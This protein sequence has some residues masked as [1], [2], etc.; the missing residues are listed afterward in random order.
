VELF[1][2]TSEI[3]EI[4]SDSLLRIAAQQPVLIHTRLIF[5]GGDGLS[6]WFMVNRVGIA[7][8]HRAIDLIGQQ[9]VGGTTP[10]RVI[11]V[12]ARTGKC[13]LVWEVPK[14]AA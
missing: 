1:E 9:M 14:G 5:E 4:E 13:Q 6:R 2:S 12:D 11:N 3:Y 10:L 8:L 7:D